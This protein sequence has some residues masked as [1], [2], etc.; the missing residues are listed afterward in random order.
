[1]W[2]RGLQLLG[3]LASLPRFRPLPS[4]PPLERQRP[5]AGV[6]ARPGLSWEPG[7]RL[8]TRAAASS[9]VGMPILP[10][11]RTIG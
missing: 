10:G 7:A 6:C 5:G 9:D 2:P 1:M 4:S 8:V 11:P 3:V